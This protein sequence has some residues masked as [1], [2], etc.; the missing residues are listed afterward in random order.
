M[1][2]S[3]LKCQKYTIWIKHYMQQNMWS[4][5]AIRETIDNTKYMLE[6]KV[7]NWQKIAFICSTVLI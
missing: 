5:I 3:F 2:G 4:F 1:I 6:L 7:L